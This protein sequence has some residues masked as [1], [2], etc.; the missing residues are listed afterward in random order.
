MRST[1]PIFPT[2]SRLL[3]PLQV[4]IAYGAKFMTADLAAPVPDHPKDLLFAQGHVFCR[5]V[6]GGTEGRGFE[7][8]MNHTDIRGSG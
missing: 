6:G 2:A 5:S 7:P 4:A 3:R 8:L 1:I